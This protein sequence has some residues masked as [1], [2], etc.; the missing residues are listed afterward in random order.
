MFYQ[1]VMETG[2]DDGLMDAVRLERIELA[3]QQ[4]AAVEVN[5]ALGPVVD[6]MAEPRALTGGKNDRLHFAS[7]TAFQM[8]P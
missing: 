5:E 3:V 8:R 6:E 4:S 1:I 7:G 2:D